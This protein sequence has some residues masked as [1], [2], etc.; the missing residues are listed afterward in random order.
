MQDLPDTRVI[1]NKQN[2][3]PLSHWTIPSKYLV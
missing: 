1:I 2:A 3:G